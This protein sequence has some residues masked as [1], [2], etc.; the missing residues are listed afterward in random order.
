M[1]V[2]LHLRNLSLV[3]VVLCAVAVPRLSA[4]KV[5]LDRSG[6]VYVLG[7][8]EIV[9]RNS[10]V[11]D[12]GDVH[13]LHVG[14]DVAVIRPTDNYYVPVGVLRI[15]ETGATSSHAAGNSKVQPQ[16]G[17][18]VMFVREFSE[19][20]TPELHRNS[21]FREQLVKDSGANGYSTVRRSQ[22]SVAMQEYQ[23]RYPKWRRSDKHVVGFL[24]GNSFSD[25][26]EQLIQP[27]LNQIDLFRDSRREG[28]NSLAAAGP[29]WEAVMNVLFGPTVAERHA[30]AQK[31]ISDENVVEDKAALPVTSIQRLVR[32]ELFE[33]LEE[34]QNLISYLVARAIEDPPRGLD[35]WL[36]LR[37]SQSQ[38]PQLADDSALIDQIRN[39]IQKLQDSR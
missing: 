24:T 21:F 1:S 3:M 9:A 12:L 4:Q 27:L 22:I 26:R 30:A 31:V 11:I 37:L 13:T 23:S 35:F 2:Y 15:Q 25:G 33:R 39:V 16:A 28:S 38:F 7:R 10:A 6:L 5:S 20:K 18:V 17:D 14:N 29:G 19:L 36:P 34:E 8:I 32:D